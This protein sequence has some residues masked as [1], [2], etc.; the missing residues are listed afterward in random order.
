MREESDEADMA[1]ALD[2]FDRVAANIEKL[3]GVW[4]QLCDLTPDEIAFGLDTAEREILVRS[5]AHIAGQL[6]AID[7]FRVDGVPMQADEIAQTRLDY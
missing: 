2:Q 7:G 1:V 5:F 3:E 4:T 6:P